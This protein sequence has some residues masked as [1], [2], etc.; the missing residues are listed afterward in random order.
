MSPALMTPKP[1]L[2]VG[3]GLSGLTTAVAL[4]QQRV[5]VV[6]V[7]RRSGISQHPRADGFTARTVEIFRSLGFGNDTVPEK[8]VDFKLRR[9]RV[10]SITGQWFDE[11]A[12]GPKPGDAAPKPVQYSAYRGATTPQDVL[13]PVLMHEARRLGVEVR[14]GDELIGLKQDEE[15]TI[16][17]VQNESGEQYRTEASYVVA[18]DGNRSPVREMLGI[19]RH[20]HGHVNSTRSVLFRAP[21]L[22]PYLRKGITQFA[23]DQPD[24]KALLL[25]YQDGRC[26]VHLP[27]T[28]D[29]SDDYLS[30]QVHR[31]LGKSETELQVDIL[32]SGRWELGGYVAEKFAVGRVFLVGDSAHSLP[33]NRGGYGVNTGIADAHNLAWKLAS[34][35]KGK[36]SAKL[37][38]TY[39]A[40]RLPVAWLR[41]DQIFA[42]NDF[43]ALQKESGPAKQEGTA[44]KPQ[45]ALSDEVVEFGQIYRSS[46]IT[47]KQADLPNAQLPDEW[48]GQPGTR[49]PHVWIEQNGRPMSTLELFDYD[50]TLVAAD[51]AWGVA[52]GASP[53]AKHVEAKFVHVTEQAF[54]EAF[55]VTSRGCSL[56]RPDGYIAWR[57]EVMA[58]RPVDAIEGALRI[59]SHPA[60]H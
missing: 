24:L 46:G 32:G 44:R 30:R 48:S 25:A 11:L 16:C 21:A 59:A 57:S 55:G 40:E 43:K 33:P 49:A 53:Q 13:E 28:A 26:V 36:S 5:S 2:V 38:E 47:G 37:L 58:E 12:W 41:H 45:E 54:L 15:G 14:L 18:A 19:S 52:L 56:V 60:A 42:R 20:G 17:T 6:V 8:P 7:E 4:G 39:E 22:D 51:S 31:V 34:V 9:V 29:P 35:W 10:E 1:I 27:E 3:A 50:W 23:I